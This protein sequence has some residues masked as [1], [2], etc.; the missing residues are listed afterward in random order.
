MSNKQTDRQKYAEMLLHI[1]KY[2][3]RVCAYSGPFFHVD[4]WARTHRP[5]GQHIADHYYGHHIAQQGSII[6]GRVLKSED[7]PMREPIC[8]FESL[9]VWQIDF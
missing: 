9:G 2:T 4:E 5:G 8:M 3:R 6:M 1:Q 7:P